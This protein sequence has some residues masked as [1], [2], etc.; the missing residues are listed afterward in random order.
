MNTRRF[1]RLLSVLIIGLCLAIPFTDRMI[2][3]VRAA[4]TAPAAPAAVTA[5]AAVASPLRKRSGRKPAVPLTSAANPTTATATA[6]APN[7]EGFIDVHDCT[8]VG[9]WAADLNR[10]NQSIN[11]E[12]YDGSTLIAIT[13]AFRPRPDVATFIG[14]NGLHGF[15]LPIPAALKDGTSH[16]LHIKF[17]ASTTELSGSPV[18]VNC[19]SL[20]PNYIGF[21][22]VS[23]CNTIGGWVADKNRLNQPISVSIYDGSTLITTLRAGQ[24]RNDVAAFLGDNGLHGFSTAIPVALQTGTS[25]NI[26]IRFETSTTDITGS[27]VSLNCPAPPAGIPFPVTTHPRLWVT[28]NDLPRLRSWAVSTNQVY[29]QGMLP[30]LQTAVNDY[31]TQFFPGGTGASTDVPNPTYPDP[32][33][34]QGYVGPL[35]EEEGVILAF[36]SLIDP[37]PANRILYAQYTR[38]MLMYAMNQAAKGTLSGAPFRDKLFPVY[39]RAS[40]SGAYWPLMVDWIYN[41]T[42]SHGSPIL[43]ASDKAT[44]RNVFMNWSSICET[45]STTGGDS[46]PLPGVLNSLQDLPN[47]LPY[48]F[49][50]NNY[51]TAHARLL[52]MMALAIDPTDDPPVNASQPASQ[53]H[54]SLRS[55]LSEAL[56]AWLYQQY[57]MYQDGATVASQYGVP[58]NAAGFGLASGGLPAE[59]MLY[60]VSY[61]GILQGLLALQ[62]AGFNNPAYL[63]YT[64]P[65]IGLISAP[66]WDRYVKGII[67]SMTPASA[68]PTQPG[69]SFLGQVYEFGSYGDLLRLYVT[70]DYVRPFALLALLEQQNG[71]STNVAEARWFDY[72]ALQGG[73]ANFIGRMT[74]PWS[75]GDTILYFMLYDPA[76]ALNTLTDP[77]PNYP[78]M[79]VDQ[80]TGRIV[81]H[82]DWTA[83]GTMFDYKSAWLSINH[84]DG[85][86]GQFELYRKGEWLTKEFSNYD[87]NGVGMTTYYHNTL[88]LQNFCPCGTNPPLNWWETGEWLNGSQWMIGENAGDPVNQFSSGPGYVFA[89][90]DLTN[91]YNRPNIF[92]PS[93]A[94][95]NI[96]KATRSIVWLSNDYIVTYDRATSMNTGLF[97]R[98][99][100]TLVTNPVI[101]GNTA[102]ETLPSGQKLFI[103]SLLPA[104][105]SIAARN[106][107]A[108]LTTIAELEPSQFVMTIQDTSNPAD[109]RFL[110]VLQGADAATAMVPA[111]HLQSTAGTSFDGAIFGTL[112]VYFPVSATASF[113]GTT[114]SAPAGVHTMLVTGLAPNTTYGVNIVVSGTGHSIAVS[115]SGTGGTADAAG[116]LRLT[117]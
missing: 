24:V 45:A 13:S 43:T 76:V 40:L 103:Q 51:Y 71:L 105:A 61:A 41:A 9:G 111:T 68:V 6:V 37:S 48:R 3:R 22:D 91:L 63:S 90:S 113:T 80:G 52:T 38:N 77:R 15:T 70:P 29:Q 88:G 46:P 59:G 83:T 97:K 65:Q 106:A 62:T 33:D 99:N 109:T 27:P 92:T 11:V 115:T 54:N 110:H 96:T 14:D 44:I 108:D 87:N 93:D 66:L 32:G 116:V 21:L 53:L 18:V 84:Q 100:L 1:V 23:N 28:T 5:A 94:I 81:A 112:A 69:E 10:L 36:N 17:E 4:R 25:Q 26:H 39:N 101:S 104:N 58:A 7:Y 57:A 89:A 31:K 20:T 85:N 74:N 72:N 47:N 60:G 102:T 16:S 2:K 8:S 73:S 86:A 19:A 12:L 107:T 82:S 114:I 78:T 67:S 42:D 75:L 98:W 30:V 35:T 34:T 79:F 56:G 117:F 64:G 49:A 95:T 55:Y 50:A